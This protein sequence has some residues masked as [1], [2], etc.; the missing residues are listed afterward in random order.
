M[1]AKPHKASDLELLLDEHLRR[2]GV[3]P[4]EQEA[5]LIPGRR[6]RIDRFWPS[7]TP[8]LAVEVEG[9]EWQG[10]RHGTGAGMTT[11]CEKSALLAIR[12]YRLMRV[13]G[14][15]VRSGQ[16]ALWIQEALGA[17][18]PTTEGDPVK[19]AMKTKIVHRLMDMPTTQGVE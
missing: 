18:A 8:P 15:Q 11:D 12:G 4:G 7:A 5:K 6:Y 17:T 2:L 10:G 9:G 16:A 1:T 3:P 14:G 19:R 13:T